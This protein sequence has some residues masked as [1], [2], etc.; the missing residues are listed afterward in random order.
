MLWYSLEAPQRRSSNVH[1]KHIFLWRNKKNINTFWLKKC[2]SSTTM[3]STKKMNPFSLTLN[4][5]DP[6]QMTH[7]MAFDLALQSAIV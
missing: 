7:S 2:V 5:A 1:S 3:H 6:D 4:N